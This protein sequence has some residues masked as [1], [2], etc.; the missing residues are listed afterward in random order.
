MTAILA[1]AR[2]DEIT[3]NVKTSE[4]LLAIFEQDSQKLLLLGGEFLLNLAKEKIPL[5][6][7]VINSSFV[8]ISKQ[9]MKNSKK[10]T[11]P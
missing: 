10:T 4:V 5:V 8:R 3:S 11:K 9:N 6:N 7:E 2:L 1:K